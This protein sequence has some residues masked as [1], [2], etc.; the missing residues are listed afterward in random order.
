MKLDYPLS[1]DLL[2][3]IG[4]VQSKS[5]STDFD[6]QLDV[7]EELYGDQIHF[8]FT[9]HDIQTLCERM[10]SETEY[11]ELVID[12]VGEILLQQRRKYAYLFK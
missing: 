1:E 5:I 4:E 10:K 3:L 9:G 11:D 12:R 7:A 2:S 6:K 8:S